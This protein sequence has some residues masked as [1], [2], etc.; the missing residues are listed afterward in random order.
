M[1]CRHGHIGL[2]LALESIR[3]GRGHGA[4]LD[5]VDA[6]A[7]SIGREGLLQPI[8]IAP[9]EVPCRLRRLAAMRQL[10]RKAAAWVRSGI[11]DDPGKLPGEQ[12]DNVLL[13]PLTPDRASEAL[14]G[15]Q[16][17]PRRGRRPASG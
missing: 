14:P 16:D 13:K 8:T 2:E 4:N 3:I 9:S 7:A 5:D 17:P 15:S 12:D 10:G 1:D 11:S 6:L